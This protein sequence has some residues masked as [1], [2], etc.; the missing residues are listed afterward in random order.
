MTSDFSISSIRASS[1]SAASVKFPSSMLYFSKLSLYACNMLSSA[2]RNP[3]IMPI[4]S[5]INKNTTRYFERSPTSSL[6]RRL[7]NGFFIRSP[8]LPFQIF[9][10]DLCLVAVIFPY[11]AITQFDYAVCHIFDR[12]IVRYHDD[13]IPIF[14]IDIPDQ[15]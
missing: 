3:E 4:V 10:R 8:P 1:A 14:L 13:R 11:R 6:G 9:C 15:F 7:R 2:T 5:V 12:V